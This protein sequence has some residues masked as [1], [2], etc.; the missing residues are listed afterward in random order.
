MMATGRVPK[1]SQ[2][3]LRIGISLFGGGERRALTAARQI[4]TISKRLAG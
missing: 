3:F 1:C 4:V 2:Y